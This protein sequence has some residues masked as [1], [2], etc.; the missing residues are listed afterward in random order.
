MWHNLV[1]DNEVDL[2]FSKETPIGVQTQSGCPTRRRAG[3]V[4]L[5][6]TGLV[7][8]RARF[9]SHLAAFKRDSKSDPNSLPAVEISEK[10]AIVAFGI[11]C[12]KS[13]VEHPALTD[14]SKPGIRAVQ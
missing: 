2:V 4:L 11:R 1:H 10:S 14:G 13:S 12:G 9:H 7:Q 8:R 3:I 5:S 6:R